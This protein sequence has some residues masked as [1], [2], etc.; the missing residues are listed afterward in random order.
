MTIRDGLLT[1]LQADQREH[2]HLVMIA[3]KPDIIKQAPLYL[4]LKRRG[5][6]VLLGHT[7]QHYDFNLSG[8]LI[9]EFGMTPDFNLNVDGALHQKTAQ[10]I[11]RLGDILL[12]IKKIGK[13]VIPYVHG[14]TTTA[15]AAS[16]A[17]YALEFA[18]VHVEAGIRTLTPKREVFKSLLGSRDIDSYYLALQDREHWERGSIEPFPEQFN[19]RTTEPATGFFCAPVELDKEFLLSEGFPADRIH[20]VGNT[21]A[22]ATQIA[23]ANAAHSTIFETY[24]ILASDF[25]RFCVHRRENCS[26][27]ERFTAIFEAMEQLVHTGERVLLISLYQTKAAIEQFG[28]QPRL[29]Q[30]MTKPNFIYS[31]VWPYYTD[32]I[33][34]MSRASVCATDSGSMQEEMNI[35]GI[36]CVTLR[37]GSDRAE[38]ALA[39]GNII[40]PPIDGTLIADVIRY[41]KAQARMK[42]APKLYGEHVSTKI[43][44]GVLDVLKRGSLFRFEQDR[45]KLLA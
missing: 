6:L 25:I 44:D 17:A 34:A 19:T 39:G 24:P 41:A 38:T 16:H 10:I 11:G 8:G 13:T 42:T 28:L 4:E 14:D 33:A 7:G 9:E 26:S 12:E 30:L 22:D 37:F 27:L 43:V 18:S 20:V 36:P 45:L 35:M 31:D 15:M 5:E 32:V 21:V 29:S 1:E 40:A 3:T 23:M 2:V